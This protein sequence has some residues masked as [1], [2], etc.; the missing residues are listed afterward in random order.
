[1]PPMGVVAVISHWGMD[2]AESLGNNGIEQFTVPA[3][4]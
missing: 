1:M 4:T 2:V 3:H